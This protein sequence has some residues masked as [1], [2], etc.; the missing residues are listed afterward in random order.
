MSEQTE[1][2]PSSALSGITTVLFDVN[3]TLSDMSPIGERFEQLGLGRAQAATWFAGLLRDGFALTAIGENPAFAE[4]A[5]GS[6]RVLLA[7]GR[8]DDEV[9]EGIEAVMGEFT[10]LGVHP[11]VAEGIRTLNA[12]GLRLVTLSN[13]AASVAAALLE[14]AGVADE[15]AQLLSVQDAPAWKPA[16]S[17]YEYAVDTLGVTKDETVLVAVHPWDID[18]AARAGLRTAWINRSGGGYPDY[19]RRAD[20]EVADLAE[21][22]AGMRA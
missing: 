5:T 21:L 10:G 22:A 13:G 18:G 2:T 4:L 11:D 16:A 9:A 20:V 14:R 17:S 3:E 12:A 6:L 8:S 7:P 19:F 15:F 1:Q